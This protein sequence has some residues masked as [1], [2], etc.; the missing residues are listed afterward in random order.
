MKEQTFPFKT[1]IWAVVVLASFFIFKQ[2]VKDIL[3]NSSEVNIFGVHIKV[4]KEESETL[5]IAQQEFENGVAVFNE[6][7]ASQD[8]TINSL[9]SLV[10][11]LQ[12]EIEGCSDAQATAFKLNARIVDLNAM[13]NSIK[14]EKFLSKDYKIVQAKKSNMQ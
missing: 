1:L 10:G 4:S 6:K 13:S 5:L 12:G 9:N 3:S 14:N 8:A 2:E 7:I 11:N